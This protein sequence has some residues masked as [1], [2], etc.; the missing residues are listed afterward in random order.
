MKEKWME[1]IGMAKKAL[2]IFQKYKR[3]FCAAGLFVLVVITLTFFTGE[4][5]IAKR[6]EALNNRPVSGDDYVPEKEFEIDAYAELNELIQTYFEAY[7]DGDMETLEMLASPISEMEQSYIEMITSHYEAYQN[8]KCYSKH[9]LSKDS[10]IVAA[11]YE[12]K[13]EDIDALA[14][15]M[16]LFYVQTNED[17]ELYINNLYSD[18]NRRYKENGVNKDVNKAFVKFTTQDDYVELHREVEEAYMNLIME[19]EEIYFLTKRT[20]P[21]LRQ[22]WEDTVYYARDDEPDSDMDS[23]TEDTQLPTETE[24]ETELPDSDTEEET[25]SQAPQTVYVSTTSDD[26][27][28]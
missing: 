7:V 24:S 11:Y 18:F 25:E 26:V 14:P 10:F 4:D 13:F 12:I 27:Y 19:N 22:E 16:E 15:S 9:G 2:P 5:Y 6:Q 8:I 20:I 21:A 3:I 23:E 1:M 28:V 17:G